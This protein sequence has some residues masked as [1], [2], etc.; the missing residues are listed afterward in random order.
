MLLRNKL[1]Y[2][3]INSEIIDKYV[4]IKYLTSS[5]KQQGK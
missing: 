1:D 5:S 3:I 2:G 4:S